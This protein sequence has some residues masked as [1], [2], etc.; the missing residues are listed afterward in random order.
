MDKHSGL[1]A[2]QGTSSSLNGEGISDTVTL[3][4]NLE[5]NT[6]R[7][8]GQTPKGRCCVIPLMFALQSE[9]MV[10]ARAGGVGSTGMTTK[11][12]RSFSL[13]R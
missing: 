5:D 2:H 10:G 11:W 9:G 7:E 12:L 13:E 8:T 6:L 3:W 4:M 1:Y